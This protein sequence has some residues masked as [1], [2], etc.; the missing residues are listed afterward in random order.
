[1]NTCATCFLW[2]PAKK[3]C[4]LDGKQQEGCIANYMPINKKADDGNTDS[5]R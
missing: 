3:Y 2:H 1:M 4:S 5:D